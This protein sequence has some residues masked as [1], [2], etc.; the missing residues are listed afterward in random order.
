MQPRKQL[1]QKEWSDPCRRRDLE[2]QPRGLGLGVLAR[3]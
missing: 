1:R 3:V 2:A